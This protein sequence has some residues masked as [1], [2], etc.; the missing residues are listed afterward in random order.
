MLAE[1]HKDVEG[2]G[3]ETPGH[4][5]NEHQDPKSEMW[6][7]KSKMIK[8]LELWAGLIYGCSSH[9]QNFKNNSIDERRR[10]KGRLF[11]D[12]VVLQL[13]SPL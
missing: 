11:D 3:S 10:E 12:A 6:N 13:I 9:I 2:P 7:R 8:S 5:E 4:V 1:R